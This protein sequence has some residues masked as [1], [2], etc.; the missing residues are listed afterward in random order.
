[1]PNRKKKLDF[2]P[3]SQADVNAMLADVPLVDERIKAVKVI[4][5]FVKNQP[6][7]DLFGIDVQL[8]NGEWLHMMSGKRAVM[9][10]NVKLANKICRVA[11]QQLKVAAAY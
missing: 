4:R 11:K 8:H 1:M 5:W 3:F 7:E 2:T 9:T 10:S 6:I